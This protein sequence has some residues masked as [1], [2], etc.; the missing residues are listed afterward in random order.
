[1][2][3]VRTELEGRH[4][5]V[6]GV[7]PFGQRLTKGLD[8]ITLVQ[9]AQR[10]RALERTA[11]DAVDRMTACAIGPCEGL[12]ACSAVGAAS[13]GIIRSSPIRP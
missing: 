7:D 8:R 13:A 12:A 2:D 9:R 4:V 10:R 11:G 6:T 1:M 5:V 3:L